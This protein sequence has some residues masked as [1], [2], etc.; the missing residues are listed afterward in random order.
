M[1]RTDAGEVLNLRGT[2]VGGWL[3]Q[4]DWMSPLGEFAADR[5][6]W[7]A[8]ATGGS[9]ERVLDGSQ[10]T[11]WTAGG[12]QR[13]GERITVD[14]GAAT[15]FNRLSIDNTAAPGEYARLVDIET[16]TDGSTWK[17]VATQAG[18]DGVTI[19]RFTPQVAR[20]VRLTQ[21]ASAPVGWSIGELNLFSDPVL[22]N[23]RHSAS[24]TSSAP[25]TSPSKAIDGD[26]SSVWQ[27]GAAQAPGQAVTIDLGRNVD[28]DKVLFDAGRATSNDYP[29][30]WD[31]FT[32][33]DNA[34]W[35][36]VAS[37]YG[38]GRTVLADFNGAKNGRYLRIVSNGNASNWWSVAEVAIYSGTSLD[39]GAWTATASIGSPAGEVLDGNVATRWTTSTHQAPGQSVTIDMGALATMNN[40]TIDTAKNAS[41]EQDWARG[42]ALDLSRDGSTWTT[43]ATGVGT[44]KATTIGF[45]AQAARYLR[46]TQT[47]SS[48]DRWWTIGELTAGLHNDDFSLSTTLNARFDAAT[49]QSIIATH[50]D[51]W[52]TESDLDEIAAMG[53]NLI[54]LP[55]GWSHFLNLDGSWKSDPWSKIDW[56]VKEAAARGIYVLLD[57][58]TVPGG[59]C[60]WGSCGRIGPNPNGFWGSETYHDW[61]ESIW[62]VM[63]D[64][65]R[66]NPAVAGYDL[67]NEPL[68]D[69]DEDAEDVAQKSEYYDRLYDAVRA[70]DP[71]H[72]IFLG[73]FFGPNSLAAPSVHGWTNVVYEYHPYDMPN[74]KDWSAQNQLVTNE[75]SGLP[76]RLS[77]HGVP[78]LYGEYSLYYNDDVWSRFMAG[79]NSLD[80]SWTNWT[81]KV[82]GAAG[83]GFA[84]WGFYYDNPSPV[85]VVNSDDAA[86]FRSK[87]AAFGTENFTKNER[88]VATVAK[89]TGGLA[90]FAP[91]EI[92][93]SGWTASASSSSP[94][95][96]P[97]SGIDGA[98][99]SSWQSGKAMSGD[100]W[101][102]I[103]M[104]ASHTV[105]MVTVQTAPD[106]AWD[107]PR[108][109]TLE[110]SIDG[111]NWTAAATGIAYGWK[112][113]ISIE[114][115]TARY[116]RIS[117]TGIAPQWWTLDQIAVF[118]SY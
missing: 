83:D 37:G 66:G 61:V 19:A 1:L 54:R 77:G 42:Y 31:V 105:S 92:A 87:L 3:T 103:D 72:T 97:A 5:T 11:R 16:S 7:S 69:Y 118:S 25:G 32:S 110:T 91:A 95:S 116:I 104:G 56:A 78:I 17:S 107:Y 76:A 101:Y 10:T 14:L 38:A 100:E 6:G 44:R 65:Y 34:T 22:F 36:K 89:Y 58:H 60:P 85:P 40:V 29:R 102:Q 4:E 112:R 24:A 18:V 113:P 108:G 86:T 50:Q 12:A 109:F 63:A 2:N 80:V 21:K 75:L 52:F 111:R 82:R 9:P 106:S 45:P 115:T 98:N 15:L 73:A 23:G 33:W 30:I 43:V 35:T 70:V 117:Q 114:P 88:F 71:D 41:D 26:V 46:L 48:P 62:T 67:I 84:Y 99:G 81:Y 96:T 28:M 90:A 13:G 94:W 49:T 59:G 39:R 57:L 68:I 51:T 55:I 79:L 27:S 47:G 64:R 53:M 20:F 8:S 74:Q 93:H